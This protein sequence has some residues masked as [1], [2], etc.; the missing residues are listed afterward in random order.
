MNILVKIDLRIFG[1]SAGGRL[2][3]SDTA[4]CEQTHVRSLSFLIQIY[5]DIVV[6]AALCSHETRTSTNLNT[7][8]NFRNIQN[9]SDTLILNVCDNGLATGTVSGFKQNRVVAG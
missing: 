2:P 4:Q 7:I 6:S 3:V 5:D 9:S 1:R 8:I